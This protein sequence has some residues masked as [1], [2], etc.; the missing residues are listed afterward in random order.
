MINLQLLRH[1]EEIVQLEPSLRDAPTVI[2]CA[3]DGGEDSVLNR[4]FEC[5]FSLFLVDDA[6]DDRLGHVVG[7]DGGWEA[8]PYILW[9]RGQT[10]FLYVIQ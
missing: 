10:Y 8:A 2:Q 9:W 6:V 5:V 3:R 4:D 7:G 1:G